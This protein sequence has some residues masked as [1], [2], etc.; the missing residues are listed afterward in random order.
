M[1]NISDEDQAEINVYKQILEVE[2]GYEFVGAIVQESVTNA[3]AHLVDMT[4]DLNNREAY[5]YLK[6]QKDES[7]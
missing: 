6:E 1:C 3:E 7:L 2:G 4:I 5:T